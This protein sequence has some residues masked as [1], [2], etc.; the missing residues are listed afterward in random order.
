MASILEFKRSL[1][2]A[3]AHTAAD[4]AR[5]PADIVLFPGVRY[6]RM[7]EEPAPAPKQRSRARRRDCLD[8]DA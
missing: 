8:L 1:T 6:E 5:G 7:T 3:K 2:S 4:A